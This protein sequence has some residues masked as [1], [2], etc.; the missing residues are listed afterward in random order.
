MKLRRIYCVKN[1]DE[2][3]K[4]LN[5]KRPISEIVL[6]LYNYNTHKDYIEEIQKNSAMKAD[7]LLSVMAR[8]IFILNQRQ[9]IVYR[10]K[11]FL[12]EGLLMYNYLKLFLLI[13]NFYNLANKCMIIFSCLFYQAFLLQ[14]Q[15]LFR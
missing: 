13:N 3:L 12:I 11:T 5:K 9:Q 15:A 10:F 1:V 6:N 7:I 14:D 2:L 4:K 8:K